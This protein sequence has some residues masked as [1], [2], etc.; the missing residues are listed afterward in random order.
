MFRR[1]KGE[2]Y[3]G[4]STSLVR[5]TQKRIERVR[6]QSSEVRR[7]CIIRSGTLSEN[8]RTLSQLHTGVTNIPALKRSLPL[9]IAT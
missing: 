6:C 1:V 3:K 5:P 8:N 4:L 2:I 7:I 9:D